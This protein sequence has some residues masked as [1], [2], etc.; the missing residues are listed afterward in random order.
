MARVV[1]APTAPSAAS[2]TKLPTTMP[3]TVLYSCCRNC[4]AIMGR[5]NSNIF[6]HS[7]PTVISFAG[8]TGFADMAAP[9]FNSTIIAEMNK[10]SETQLAGNG[11]I[12]N[13]LVF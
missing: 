3:S 6:F 7:A 13:K 12:F 9:S 5:A 2:L 4:P 1:Q 10:K 11:H 8:E